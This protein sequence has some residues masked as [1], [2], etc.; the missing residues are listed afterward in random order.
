MAKKRGTAGPALD[1][2][3]GV[4]ETDRPPAEI[5]TL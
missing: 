3:G 1:R 4:V 2:L 5:G